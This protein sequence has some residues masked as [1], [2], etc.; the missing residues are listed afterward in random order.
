MPDR[1]R[2]RKNPGKPGQFKTK[3]GD[4]AELTRTR[5]ERKEIRCDKKGAGEKRGK[6]KPHGNSGK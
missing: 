2:H 6:K 5:A 3:L 4:R 1:G